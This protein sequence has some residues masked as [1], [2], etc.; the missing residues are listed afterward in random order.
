M[1]ACSAM[2]LVSAEGSHNGLRL[3][4]EGHY[5]YTTMCVCVVYDN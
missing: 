3:K 5:G 4:A 1:V 2:A